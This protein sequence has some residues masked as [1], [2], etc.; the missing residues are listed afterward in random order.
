MPPGA[1]LG[2]NL[3][4]RPGVDQLDS[5]RENEVGNLHGTRIKLDPCLLVLVL[6]RNPRTVMAQVTHPHDS[7]AQF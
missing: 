7:H 2:V 3:G 1:R 6:T 5:R 4:L